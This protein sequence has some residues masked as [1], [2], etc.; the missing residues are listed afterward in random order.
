V[1]GLIAPHIDLERGNLTYARAYAVLRDAGRIDRFLILGTSHGPT[2]QLLAPTRKDYDTPLGPARTDREAVDRVVSTLGDDA[3]DDEFCHKNEHSIEFQTIF[4]KL[5]HPES[6]IVP[7]LC[8]SL[9]NC[10][11]DGAEPSDSE[12]VERAV[13]AVKAAMDDDKRT[14]VIAAADLAHVGPRFGGPPLTRELLTETE[15]A[16]RASLDMAAALD[17]SGWYRSVS[18]GGD[19]RN[20]CGLSPIYFLLRALERGQGHLVNYRRC[21]SPDQCVT[22]GAMAFLEGEYMG[23]DAPEDRE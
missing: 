8:G 18:A 4:L 15:A 2:T 3:F 1:L 6:T 10:V 22:I 21:E 23:S 5:M 20:T 13:S 19:P 7:I 9:R 11:E 12:E 14:V 17:A 16:D